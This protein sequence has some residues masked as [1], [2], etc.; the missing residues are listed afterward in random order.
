MDFLDEVESFV[1]AEIL[2]NHSTLNPFQAYVYTYL[3]IEDRLNFLW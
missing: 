1:Y 2:L 3:P